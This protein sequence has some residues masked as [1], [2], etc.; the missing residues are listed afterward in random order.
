MSGRVYVAPD[1]KEFKTRKAAKEH[2]V[3]NKLAGAIS[4][5]EVEDKP[6]KTETSK[7]GKAPTAGKRYGKPWQ[8]P[9]CKKTFNMESNPFIFLTK[10]G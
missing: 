9:Q 2:Q 3:K 10:A 6:K 4:V 7:K 5:A 1:G 8:C